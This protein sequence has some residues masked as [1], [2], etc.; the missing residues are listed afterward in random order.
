MRE[1]PLTACLTILSSVSN[2]FSA[3]L[4]IYIKQCLRVLCTRENALD[5]RYCC[6]MVNAAEESVSFEE[7]GSD[8]GFGCEIEMIADFQ[9]CRAR[10]EV[11]MLFASHLL[12]YI[13]Q[14]ITALTRRDRT[15]LKLRKHRCDGMCECTWME[16]EEHREASEWQILVSVMITPRSTCFST[17]SMADHSGQRFENCQEDP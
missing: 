3:G 5:A 11:R 1:M 15:P 8:H 12:K 2:S 14:T 6:F 10:I 16:S 7:E 13:C 17:M 4:H 9:A